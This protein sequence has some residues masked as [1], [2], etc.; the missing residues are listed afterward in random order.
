MTSFNLGRFLDFIF[1]LKMPQTKTSSLSLVSS[2]S[3]LVTCSFIYSLRLSL[4]LIYSGLNTQIQTHKHTNTKHTN[5]NDGYFCHQHHMESSSLPPSFYNQPQV[6]QFFLM[7]PGASCL[8]LSISTI[9]R[10]RP[11]SQVFITLSLD[12][13]NHLWNNLLPP[14]SPTHQYQINFPQMLVYITSP[15]ISRECT[16]LGTRH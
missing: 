11:P 3:Y 6:Y 12:Y 13:Y 2:L 16:S 1:Q 14:T 4:L 15:I 8:F 9:N 7:S 5:T 10:L